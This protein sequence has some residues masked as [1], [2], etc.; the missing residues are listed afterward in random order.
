MICLLLFICPHDLSAR[1][2]LIAFGEHRRRAAGTRSYLVRLRS[3]DFG[4]RIEG[5]RRVLEFT[6][7]ILPSAIRG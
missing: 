6:I 3:A 1:A 5:Q 2:S 4:S 7:R